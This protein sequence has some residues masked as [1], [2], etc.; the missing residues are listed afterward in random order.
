MAVI[1]TTGEGKV[2]KPLRHASDNMIPRLTERHFL[3]K[4]QSTEKRKKPDHRDVLCVLCMA[5]GKILYSVTSIHRFHRGS[6]KET[7]DPGKL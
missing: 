5:K 2:G 1:G 6:E 4:M 7:M 3:R